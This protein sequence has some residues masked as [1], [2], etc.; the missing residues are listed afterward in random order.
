MK[1]VPKNGEKSAQGHLK[2]VIVSYADWL[3]LKKYKKKTV[4]ALLKMRTKFDEYL[5]T[6]QLELNKTSLKSYANWMQ[7]QAY[8]VEYLRHI[9]WSLKTYYR[10]LRACHGWSGHLE[11]PKLDPKKERREAL[12][13][14]EIQAVRNWLDQDQK[15]LRHLLWTLLYGCGLRRTEAVNLKLSSVKFRAKKLIVQ[16]LKGGKIRHIPL[17]KIQL[18][19]I[20]NYIEMDRP[21]PQKGFEHYLLISPR[22]KKATSLLAKEL[23][24]WQEGTGLGSRFCWHVLRHTIATELVDK[25][26]EISLVAQ[27]LGHRNWGST[28]HYLH[29]QPED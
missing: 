3:S 10:Y 22:G 29:Y 25:G 19:Q 18:E 6:E 26:M 13:S 23:P 8:S 17:S 14:K 20:A 27:F 1:T 5:F 7:E 16:G 24:K 2:M 21:I 15:P 4:D 28:H 11:L 12:N 9:H